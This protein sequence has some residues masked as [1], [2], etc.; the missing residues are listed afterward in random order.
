LATID[1]AATIGERNVFGSDTVVGPEVVIGDD[2]YI[3]PHV[4]LEGRVRLGSGNRLESHCVIGGPSRKRSRL[5]VK[6][7]PPA[8]VSVEIGDD[9]LVFEGVVIHSPNIHVTRVGNRC[10]LGVGTFVAHDVVVA[11][12]VV[13]NAHCSLGG[14]A[15]IQERA[16]LGLGVALHPRVVVGGLAMVG[17]GAMVID[18]VAP[19]A[20]V[21]GVPA[22]FLHANVRGLARFDVE[23]TSWIALESALSAARSD[24][25][26]PYALA[27]WR[28]FEEA[29]HRSGRARPVLTGE[30]GSA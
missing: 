25:A 9:S 1:P 8:E 18:H 6:V 19:V 12:D 4:V 26:D 29:M 16:T 21:A 5:P 23:E 11:D 2:N 17:M 15:V 28:Q 24:L 14:Y 3:G 30:L 10:S 7:T 13:V 27:L 20:T 22:V